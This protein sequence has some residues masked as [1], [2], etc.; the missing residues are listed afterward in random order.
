MFDYI[1]EKIRVKLAAIEWISR[2]GGYTV[3][4]ETK[5]GTTKAGYPS[6]PW[7]TGADCTPTERLNMAPHDGETA[8]AFVDSDGNLTTVKR[9]AK[10]IDFAANVRVVLWYDTRRIVYEGDSDREWQMI[11]D[12]IGAAKSAEMNTEGLGLARLRFA[13]VQ[14]DPAQIWNKYA[15]RTVGQGLFTWP[16]KTLAI[17]FTLTGRLVMNCFAGTLTPQASPC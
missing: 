2:T 3:Q 4:A 10:Y 14:Y 17:T 5:D 12:V 16:Y 11:K 8:I 6:A 13:S 9:T 1:G 15:M 7:Y